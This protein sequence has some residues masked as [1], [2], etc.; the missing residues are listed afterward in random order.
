MQNRITIVIPPPFRETSKGILR[1]QGLRRNN[2][3]DRFRDELAQAA[4]FP[5][6]I[7]EGTI[8]DAPAE[9]F[10]CIYN[11][12]GDGLSAE[13]G[14][15]T[16][17]LDLLRTE[18]WGSRP[19]QL[20]TERFQLAA[21]IEELRY[22]DWVFGSDAGF[23]IHGL[24]SVAQKAGMKVEERRS[25]GSAYGVLACPHCRSLAALL[26]HYLTVYE[27]LGLHERKPRA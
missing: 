5:V 22:V 1:S 25:P 18:L 21:A 23:G 15:R 9:G 24:E 12:P 26:V 10:I 17:A 8:E 27:E 6:P 20:A 11:A 13:L 19:D 16:V 3:V 2:Q 14:P 7:L 4:G